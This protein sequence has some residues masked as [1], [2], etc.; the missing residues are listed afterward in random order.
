MAFIVI[1]FYNILSRVSYLIKNY[2][3]INSN[4]EGSVELR[5]R[6]FTI[7]YFF[8]CLVVAVSFYSKYVFTMISPV[9]GGGKMQKVE[10]IVKND[11]ASF[12]N[13]AKINLKDN[14]K[15]G[16]V[17][18][19]FEASDFYVVMINKNSSGIKSIRINKDLIDGAMYYS[20]KWFIF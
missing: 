4:D 17:D 5:A 18:V 15:A 8:I 7:M 11:K 12:F 1:G 3:N 6:F 16:P 14:K 2:E 19:I 20:N 10:F 13:I 9:Y